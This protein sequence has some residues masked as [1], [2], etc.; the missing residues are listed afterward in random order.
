MRKLLSIIVCLMAFAAH[1]QELK[2]TVYYMGLP[3]VSKAAKDIHVGTVKPADDDI[4]S[5]IMDSM[6]TENDDT[7]PFYI[8][9]VSKTLFLT[10]DKELKQSLGN[11]CRR[12]IQ[13]RPDD[14]VL[15]L[16][17]KTVKP[18]YKEAWAK[19]I[20]DDIDANCETTLKECFRQSRLLALEMCNTDNKDKLEI[21]YNQIR[22]HLQLSVR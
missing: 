13:N 16:F 20:A 5:S 9:L 14:V 8:F 1:A 15:L 2:P 19:A 21:I 11:A 7:R 18:V 6:S 22:A 10:K 4:M 12:Y 3:N 17:S